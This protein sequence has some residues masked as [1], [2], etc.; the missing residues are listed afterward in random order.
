M[1]KRVVDI[2]DYSLKLLSLELSM[3]FQDSWKDA[4]T[5]FRVQMQMGSVHELSRI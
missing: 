5:P 2:L 4:D 3:Q 1:R